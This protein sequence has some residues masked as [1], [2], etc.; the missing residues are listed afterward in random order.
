MDDAKILLE[1]DSYASDNNRAYY[2]LEKACTALLASE[3]IPTKSH[4]GIISQFN[5]YFVSNNNTPFD[6]E[7][8]KIVARAETIRSKSDYDDFYVANKDETK[9]LVSNATTLIA[10]VEEYLLRKK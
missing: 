3:K 4:R 9:S 1:K 2:A 10:K 7:D 8:Y 5:Q 6:A